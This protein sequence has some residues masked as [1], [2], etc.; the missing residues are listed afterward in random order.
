MAEKEKQPN[1]QN[2]KKIKKQEKIIVLIQRYNFGAKC[3]DF[4][5]SPCMAENSLVVGW[6]DYSITE[7]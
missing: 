1:K 5:Y 4:I 3:E 7:L 6:L 2:Q